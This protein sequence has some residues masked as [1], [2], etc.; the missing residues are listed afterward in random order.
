[1]EIRVT[2]N[3]GSAGGTVLQP[4][5][6]LVTEEANGDYRL[7]LTVQPDREH[8]RHR[9]LQC[10]KVLRARVPGK[11]L[12]LRH[13]EKTRGEV[14]VYRVKGRSVQVKRET[15][16]GAVTVTEWH[17]VPLWRDCEQTARL[18]MLLPGDEVT[19]QMNDAGGDNG[20]TCRVLT[21]TGS[22][23]WAE[24][25]YLSEKGVTEGDVYTLC[26]EAARSAQ[27]ACFR[28]VKVEKESGSGIR[29]R[30]RH[31]YYDCD[32]REIPPVEWTETPLS[33]ALAY[34]SEAN[35]QITLLTDR[36][37]RVSG[38]YEGA[39]SDI[40]ARLCGELDLQLVR[41]GRNAYL[42]EAGNTERRFSVNT[43]GGNV[44]YRLQEDAENV[45]TAFIPWV[46]GAAGEAVLSPERGKMNGEKTVYVKK[47]SEAEARAEAERRLR[48]GADESRTAV[49]VMCEGH[50]LD[51]CCV[52]DRVRVTD[53]KLDTDAE[54]AVCELQYDALNGRVTKARLGRGR[55]V[56]KEELLEEKQ[57][58]WQRLSGKG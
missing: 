21:R 3:A 54:G 58:S 41:E 36:D 8:G 4:E 48:N 6:A 52:F 56:L 25:Q 16:S 53:K 46:D 57:G 12:P 1:M 22:R 44:K 32:E 47:K 23:G 31:I 43:E 18:G 28:I 30:A 26:D 7:D 40:V 20:N 49:T 2:E 37:T 38:C 42:L 50:E 29:A 5:S 17:A 9:L 55:P 15:M 33:E 19:A 13:I 34:L 35:G 45:I 27:E 11:N 39:C 24:R 51:G 10:G 14:R